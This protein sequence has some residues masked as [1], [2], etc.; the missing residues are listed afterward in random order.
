MKSDFDQT[1]E[2]KEIDDKNDLCDLFD[3]IQ[4][5]INNEVDDIITNVEK[6]IIEGKPKI[7]LIRRLI[8]NYSY[9]LARLQSSVSEAS[10]SN[11]FTNMIS[12]GILTYDM[13]SIYDKGKSKA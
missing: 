10:F 1:V 3:K 13:K 9:Q 2:F 12:K 8:T 6:C 4:E 5:A 7:N 11:H